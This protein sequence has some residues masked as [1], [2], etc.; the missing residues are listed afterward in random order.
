ML[1]W[2][3]IKVGGREACGIDKEQ[4]TGRFHSGKA[5]KNLSGTV[6]DVRAANP[7]LRII[8]FMTRS[9]NDKGD[10]LFPLQ[11]GPCEGVSLMPPSAA[12]LAWRWMRPQD[13]Y[14]KGVKSCRYR[15][16]SMDES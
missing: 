3:Y 10:D 1:N 16:L 7:Q 15:S 9:L 14:P 13:M 6:S 12:A 11:D 5:G 4:E 2:Y 8:G